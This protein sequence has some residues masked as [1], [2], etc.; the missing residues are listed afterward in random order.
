MLA[1]LHEAP[2]LLPSRVSM[3]PCTPDPALH[4]LPHHFSHSSRSSNPLCSS[5]Q[6]PFQSPSPFLSPY[7]PPCPRLVHLHKSP[8]A[9]RRH[10]W[11]P[12]VQTP[13]L[14]VIHRHHRQ[15]LFHNQSD[16]H[17][18]DH[19]QLA[20]LRS[21]ALNE[22]LVDTD[23]DDDISFVSNATSDVVVTQYSGPAW[24]RQ[25]RSRC[26]RHG[27]RRDAILDLVPA[28]A[29]ATCTDHDSP[30]CTRS[31]AIDVALS[32]DERFVAPSFPSS[33]FAAFVSG[34]PRAP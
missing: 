11:E 19:L 34:T 30:S 12:R 14:I 1:W 4:S 15:P 24:P 9:T 10:A 18:L 25:T 13:F 6:P 2:L 31:S 32:Y 20:A 7:H 8:K 23:H 21:R 16:H 27:V 5:M 3:H 33:P 28:R 29:S 22:D 26:W 17:C